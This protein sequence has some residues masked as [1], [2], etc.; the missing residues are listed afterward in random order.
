MNDKA[1]RKIQQAP[2]PADSIAGDAVKEAI[3]ETNAKKAP[4]Q[5][6]RAA[7]VPESLMQVLIDALRDHVPHK[8]ADP[9]LRDCRAVQYGQFPVTPNER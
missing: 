5:M 7:L 8:V 1:Q 9:L 4:M 3:A 6:A 2:K